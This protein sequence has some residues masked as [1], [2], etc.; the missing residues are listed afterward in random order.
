MI[1]TGHWYSAV[2]ARRQGAKLRLDE[3]GFRIFPDGEL[4]HQNAGGELQFS[5]R[6]GNIPRKI[7]LPD[8][9]LFT[10]LENDQ[11]DTWLA[12]SG[13]K[14][15]RR[16]WAY[17]L[18]S[19]WAWVGVAFL[20]TIAS[21]FVALYWGLPW[22]SKKIAFEL[23]VEVV[24]VVSSGT[25]Q[26]LESPMRSPCRRV[27]SW[28]PTGWWKWPKSRRYWTPSCSTRSAMS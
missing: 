1:L 2:S 11:V 10:T 17:I 12:R 27:T 21:G 3:D 13:H 19:N 16:H 6:I 28:L 26:T 24:E 9:S 7:Q 25:L 15:G 5:P 4:Q 23:P 8:G 20:F 14:D 18:E 22:A